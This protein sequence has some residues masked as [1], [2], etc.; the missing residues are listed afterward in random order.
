MRARKRVAELEQER[1][2]LA[3]AL[4]TGAIPEDLAR[5]EQARI[6]QELGEAQRVMA[7]S[8]VVYGRIEDTLNRALALVGRAA[9]V[10]RLSGPQVRRLSNQ[11]FF[12]KLRISVDDGGQQV[13]APELRKPWAGLSVGV[14]ATAMEHGTTNLDQVVLVEVL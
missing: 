13:V 12:A 6:H 3:S 4:V 7:T 8:E 11:C 2:R 9:E 14:G 1:R 5:E 10:Y